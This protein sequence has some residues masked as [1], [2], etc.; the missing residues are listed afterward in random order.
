M[1]LKMSFAFGFPHFWSIA[2][3]FVCSEGSQ[4]EDDTVP[5]YLLSIAS[6]DNIKHNLVI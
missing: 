4:Q 5:F 6:H 1:A 2:K 3:Y